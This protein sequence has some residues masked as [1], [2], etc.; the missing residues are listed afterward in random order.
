MP[1]YPLCLTIA[2]SGEGCLLMSRSGLNDF[3]LIEIFMHAA[4][5]NVLSS[6]V[7]KSQYSFS[8]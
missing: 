3:E 4:T 8:V 6:T 5:F 1:G 2:L 7:I